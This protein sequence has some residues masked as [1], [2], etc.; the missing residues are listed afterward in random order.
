[1]K[2]KHSGATILRIESAKNKGASTRV[3]AQ[4]DDCRNC[5]YLKN[6]DAMLACLE[7]ATR[8]AKRLR[9]GQ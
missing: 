1:M 6:V 5:P 8:I 7:A 2:E 3:P 9:L 4:S